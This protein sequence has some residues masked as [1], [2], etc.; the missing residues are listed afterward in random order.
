MSR[1]AIVLF[2]LG[3]PDS[4][5]AVRPFLFNLFSD[6]AI[7]GKTVEINNYPLT[8]VG[9]ADQLKGQV[10]MA[11]VV[12]RDPSKLV[13][14]QSRL[15]LEGEIMKVVDDQLGAV[16]RAD[17]DLV[18]VLEKSAGQRLC[19]F[20]RSD[21]ADFLIVFHAMAKIGRCDSIDK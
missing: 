13:D 19:D 14:D 7:V 17:G 18:A 4:L 6:P 11:F 2:N 12:V 1:T 5:K 21:D 15:K 16:A 3:G 10:A 9:V 8:V 20:A